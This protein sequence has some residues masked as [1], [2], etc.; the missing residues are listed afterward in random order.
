M[1]SAKE[2][3]AEEIREGRD[4]LL[5]YGPVSNYGDL[6]L[7]LALELNKLRKDMTQLRKEFDAV[8]EVLRRTP[9][10]MCS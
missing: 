1:A 5:A 2:Y 7:N 3:S 8:V 10:C 9:K 4:T 6:P